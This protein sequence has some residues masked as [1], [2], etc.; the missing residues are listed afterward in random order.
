MR[1]WV[2]SGLQPTAADIQEVCE[3]SLGIDE[4]CRIDPNFVLPDPDVRMR[5]RNWD[6]E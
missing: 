5:P 2:D 1:A 3:D 6:W 4:I